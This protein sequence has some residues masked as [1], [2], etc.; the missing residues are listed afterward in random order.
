MPVDT[1]RVHAAFQAVKAACDPAAR[2]AALERAC[3]E[4]P[5]LRQAVEI[6]LR[7][8]EERNALTMNTPQPL[9]TDVTQGVVLPGPTGKSGDAVSDSES[10][11]AGRRPRFPAGSR[12]GKY[13]IRRFLARGGMGEVY[14]G[15]DPLIE[16]DVALKVLP[17]SLATN[18]DAL[19]RFRTE[20]RAIGKLLHSHTVALYEI[21]EHEQSFFLAMEFVPG[22][23]LADLLAGTGK[24]EW[25]RATRFLHEVCQGLSAAHAVGVMHRD[26][27]PENLLLSADDHIKITDFGLA[28]AMQSSNQASLNLTS[29]GQAL[30]TPLYMSPEQFAGAQV[31][32]RSDLYSAGA[33]YYYCLTGTRPFAHA[34]D[35]MQLMFAHANAPVPDPRQVD[36]QI[37]AE[38]AAV[39]A[40]A[41][42]KSPADRYGSAAEMG[43]ALAPLLVEKPKQAELVFWLVE[44]SRLQARS[45]QTMLAEFGVGR[46]RVFA[47]VADTLA[48]AAQG[49]PTAI[50]SALHLSDGTGEDLLDKIR[51]LP[52]GGGVFSFL[53]SSDTALTSPAS[54]RPGRPLV[55]TK[56]ITKDVLAQVVERVRALKG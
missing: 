24:L 4:D 39:I 43:A 56:P 52:G 15:F 41:M 44:P 25:K 26:I 1:N 47:A 33:T 38:C 6:M 2:A 34:T 7:Q 17:A 31:D 42:A 14:H 40:R 48:A 9:L 51:A 10:I 22:G 30:G 21:G 37:P 13:E 46:T 11:S 55:L 27:K 16:R 54:Y 45:L 50:L 53:L 28:K 35:L 8:E 49:L 12:L 29:P 20:A 3:G 5:G 36:P 19:K 18:S 23:S 32:H